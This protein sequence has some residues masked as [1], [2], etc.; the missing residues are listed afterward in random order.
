MH[1]FALLSIVR[2]ISCG[3]PPSEPDSP[4]IV[5]VEGTSVTL[6]WTQPEDTGG[7]AITGYIIKY[8][9]DGLDLNQYSTEQIGPDHTSY[10]FSGKL[11][12]EKSYRFAVAAVNDVGEGQASELSDCVPTSGTD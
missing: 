12:P 1:V 7:R 4:V 2:S 3:S 11:A 5:R 9:V 10:R 6:K 8:G